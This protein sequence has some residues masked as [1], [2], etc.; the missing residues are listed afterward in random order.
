M[1]VTIGR[2]ELL[3]A[4]GGA[5]AWPLAARA[6]QGERMRRVAI[7]MTIADDPRGQS[8]VAAF[9][10][11]EHVKKQSLYAV[12]GTARHCL[13]HGRGADPRER[14]NHPGVRLPR[15]RDR[16]G[17]SERSA[18]LCHGR[19]DERA[20]DWDCESALLQQATAYCASSVRAAALNRKK[21]ASLPAIGPAQNPLV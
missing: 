13:C 10:C 4:L 8:Y 14:P 19:R 11:P 1:T 3:G 2:R 18:A 20:R 21:S 12:L 5:A 15:F 17:A 9:Q 16:N 6:Q 7:L